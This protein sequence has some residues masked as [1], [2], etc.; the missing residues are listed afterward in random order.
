MWWRIWTGR[1][2][3]CRGKSKSERVKRVIIGD[4]QGITERKGTVYRILSKIVSTHLL[5]VLTM[6]YMISITNKPIAAQKWVIYGLA[7]GRG[8][9]VRRL[10]LAAG[11]NTIVP[12][13]S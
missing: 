4:N 2:G 9:C 3:G 11:G 13:Q 1:Q 8:F 6:C 7:I 10:S 5:T 12:E